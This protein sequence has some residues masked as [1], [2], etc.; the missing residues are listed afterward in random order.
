[1][2]IFIL[3]VLGIL[4]LILVFVGLSWLVVSIRRHP[5]LLRIKGTVLTVEK[6]YD[7]GGRAWR[8]IFPHHRLHHARRATGEIPLEHRHHSSDPETLRPH[9]FA[10]AR[11][12]EHRGLPRPHRRA[13]TLH[14]K[15][16]AP[17]RVEFRISRQW[18]FVVD[19]CRK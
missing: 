2:T 5:Y 19:G 4:G 3:V 6:K 18:H 8:D 17:L 10:V 15:P 13:R 16:V 14:R 11:R 7:R 12:A 1:M 9:Y